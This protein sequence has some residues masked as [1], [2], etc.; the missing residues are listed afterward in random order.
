MCLALMLVAALASF[1]L[2]ERMRRHPMFDLSLLHKPAFA[3]GS[4]RPPLGRE[5]RQYCR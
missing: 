3:G 1:P 5:S 4:G 2:I